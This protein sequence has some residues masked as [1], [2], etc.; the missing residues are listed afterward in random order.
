MYL[1]RMDWTIKAKNIFRIYTPVGEDLEKL[2]AY[3]LLEAAANGRVDSM[4]ISL[5]GN[6]PITATFR[7]KDLFPF[8]ELGGYTVPV[9]GK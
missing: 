9:C 2:R 7:S 8:P 4:R 1:C 6:N 5:H 3:I